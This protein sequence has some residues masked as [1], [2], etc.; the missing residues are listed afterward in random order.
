MR[1]ADRWR[2]A[3]SQQA[4]NWWRGRWLP[5]ARRVVQTV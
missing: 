1:R 5:Q 3:E 2:N 4:E